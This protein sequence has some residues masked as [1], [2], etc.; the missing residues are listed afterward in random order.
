M[1]KFTI[2]SSHSLWQKIKSERPALKQHRG[3]ENYESLIERIGTYGV[4]KRVILSDGKGICTFKDG[5]KE[6]IAVVDGNRIDVYNKDLEYQGSICRNIEGTPSGLS[7]HENYFL[8]TNKTH[9]SIIRQNGEEVKLTTKIPEQIAIHGHYLHYFILQNS[10]V[11]NLGDTSDPV[12]LML[13]RTDN[14]YAKFSDFTV[15][16]DRALIT[17]DNQIIEYCINDD[18]HEK[19]D[20]NFIKFGKL[21]TQESVKSFKNF[22][23]DPDYSE[24]KE[25]QLYDIK[26]M[27]NK[28]F[29]DEK[30]TIK[31]E[32]PQGLNSR[33][34]T[35]ISLKDGINIIYKDR[36]GFY[37]NLRTIPLRRT[38]GKLTAISNK[39]FTITTLN[40]DKTKED[41]EKENR[42]IPIHEGPKTEKDLK[43]YNFTQPPENKQQ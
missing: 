26:S 5:E 35:L 38:P 16:D 15:D 40:N 12:F 10:F 25:K 1:Y 32:E 36:D 28:D 29:F 3:N 6:N 4:D 37:L 17:S 21:R 42:Q 11:C 34:H 13:Y 33:N 14:R 23:T 24:P 41:P 19:K 39:I 2:T 22:D 27:E 30:E 8:V 9:Y 31:I 18:V 20:N 7:F 43:D